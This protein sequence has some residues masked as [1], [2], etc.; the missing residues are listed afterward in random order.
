WR[1]GRDPRGHMDHGLAVGPQ[2][3]G[4]VTQTVWLWTPRPNRENDEPSPRTANASSSEKVGSKVR[5]SVQK[6]WPESV[7]GTVLFLASVRASEID[8][9]RSPKSLQHWLASF[10]FRDAALDPAQIGLSLF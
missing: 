8:G 10:Q 6:Y 9:R 2:A 7:P 3:L 4:S 1:P 5:S